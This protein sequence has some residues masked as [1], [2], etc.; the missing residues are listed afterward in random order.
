[1]FSG[2]ILFGVSS[3]LAR[4]KF[5]HPAVSCGIEFFLSWP[6]VGVEE[7]VPS[8]LPEAFEGDFSGGGVEECGVYGAFVT[9]DA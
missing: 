2:F 7:S 6:I 1:V 8:Q 9:V 3:L 4:W 5:C